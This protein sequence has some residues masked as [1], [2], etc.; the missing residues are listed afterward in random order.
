[1]TSEMHL[2]QFTKRLEDGQ[3]YLFFLLVSVPGIWFK[4][5]ALP[6]L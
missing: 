4:D 2:A 1:M 5:V 6:L 3:L